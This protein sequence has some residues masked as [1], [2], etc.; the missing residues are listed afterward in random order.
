MPHDQLCLTKTRNLP[1]IKSTIWI[2]PNMSV[3]VAAGCQWHLFSLQPNIF[4]NP[5]VSRISMSNRV[6]HISWRK[7]LLCLIHKIS[8]LNHMYILCNWK[9]MCAYWLVILCGCWQWLNQIKA[10]SSLTFSHPGA[11]YH[12]ILDM[13]CKI[14]LMTITQMVLVYLQ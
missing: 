3:V 7:Y 6:S 8:C 2:R 9:D 12:I 4:L 1:Q 13:K 5:K 14:E 10:D 11:H